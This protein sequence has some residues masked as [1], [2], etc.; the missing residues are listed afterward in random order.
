[1]N[2]LILENEPVHAKYQAKLLHT[3]SLSHIN[4]INLH[5]KRFS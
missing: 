4:E 2:I 5:I 3:I 1:M